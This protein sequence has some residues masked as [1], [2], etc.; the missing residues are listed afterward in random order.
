MERGGVLPALRQRERPVVCEIGAGWGG[1]AYQ[2]KTL[3]PNATY[4]IV[5]FP[6]LFLYSATYLGTVFPDARL[7]FVGTGEDAADVGDA[8]FV[9]VPQMLAGRDTIGELDLVV[10]MVSFQ[11]MTDAQ[12]RRYAE[13]AASAGCP[14]IYSF[15]R[16]RSAYNTE[17][18]RVSD[19][20]AERYRLTEVPV[21]E[22]DYTNAMK[23]APKP[24]K[25]QERSEIN[26]RHLVGRLDPSSVGRVL[27]DAPL[28]RSRGT[29][30]TGSGGVVLGMTLYN[31]ARHL[32][33]AIE[34]LLA[35]THRDFTLILLD[36]ASADETE[37]VAR[38]YAA[39]DARIR[40][41]KHDV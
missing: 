5:D 32:P 21:L 13:I 28:G 41:F 40:Y 26:Y 20:L 29:G 30:P 31:N 3:F 27:S 16:E 14:F 18:I 15:N 22:S 10:N 4:V 35:Q 34:S 39:R 24:G 9:F 37:S 25:V 17:L 7:A 6:E 38:G 8:D 2:F 36:D 33:E 11:E 19:A 1:F 12:V 23:R